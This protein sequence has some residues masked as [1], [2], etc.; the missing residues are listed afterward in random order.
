MESENDELLIDARA[1]FEGGACLLA[2]MSLV[3]KKG[4]VTVEEL[5]AEVDA[6]ENTLRQVIGPEL[7][8]HL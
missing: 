4:L 6:F 2:L 1:K 5:D 3:V 7:A 8:K